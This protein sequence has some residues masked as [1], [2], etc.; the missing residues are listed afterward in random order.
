MFLCNMSQE[1]AESTFQGKRYALGRDA[2]S[3]GVK[4]VMA[5]MK[6]PELVQLWLHLIT[7]HRP[8][9]KPALV[10]VSPQG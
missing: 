10:F 1:N 6:T 5:C 3:R 4:A 2:G 9:W 8:V 7:C